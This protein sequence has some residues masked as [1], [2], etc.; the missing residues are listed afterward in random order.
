LP[1]SP[2]GNLS[3]FAFSQQTLRILALERS[4]RRGEA[5]KVLTSMLQLANLPLQHEQL[6]LELARLDEHAG[7][8][9]RAFEAGSP[10]RD[11]AIRMILV[12]HALSAEALRRRIKDPKENADVIDA[13]VYSLLYKELT[14]AKYTN[15]LADLSLV[16]SPASEF[17]Q[18]FVASAPT[19]K[20]EYQCPSMR[21]IASTL[22]RRPDDAK[23]LVCIGEFVRLNGV[24]YD[25]GTTPPESDLGGADSPFPGTNYSRLDS[26]QKVIRNS[27]ADSDAR[28][29]ALYR[30]IQCFAR[31]G[32][33]GC[34]KQEIPKHTRQL[35]FQMLQRQ[36]ADSKWAKSLKYYW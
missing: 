36:Y 23:G 8:A 26:Y 32:N 18:P 29:Y 11:K 35:W 34:G 20:S 6:E 9:E 28:A 4:N 14:G 1:I 16:P 13:A 17:L 24:H 27:H 19:P 7:H 10:V 15:F 21:E 22:E 12:E 25:Q 31:S 30:A 2:R 5:R 33:N 3:Y